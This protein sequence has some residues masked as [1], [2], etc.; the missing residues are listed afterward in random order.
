VTAANASAIAPRVFVIMILH[1]APVLPEG[2]PQL[3]QA[4]KRALN[5]TGDKRKTSR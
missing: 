4:M 2:I 1:L 5:T 3:H